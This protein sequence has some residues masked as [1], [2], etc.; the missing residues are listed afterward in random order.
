MTDKTII[1]HGHHPQVGH[2]V[3]SLAFDFHFTGKIVALF[4]GRSGKPRAVVELPNGMCI[5]CYKPHEEL[6]HFV[7]S[8]PAGTEFYHYSEK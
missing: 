6:I 2:E 1:S 7:D 3:R 5:V 8:Y 4:F